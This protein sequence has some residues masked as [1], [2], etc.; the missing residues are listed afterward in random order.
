MTLQ[1][2]IRAGGFIESEANGFYSR[3]QVTIH[4]GFTGAAV[5]Y[6]GTVLG[7][8]TATGKY[9]ASPN[10]GADGSQT[11]VAILFDD[12]DPTLGD[13]QAAVVSRDAEVRGADLTY[14]ATVV[15]GSGQAAKATQLAAVGIIVRS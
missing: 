8:L 4:G 6:A 11:A 7:K 14:D 2:R 13:V 5:L 1:N 15:A 10:T 12:V 3:D 9:T